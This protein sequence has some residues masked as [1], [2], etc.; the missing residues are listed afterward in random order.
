MRFEPCCPTRLARRSKTSTASRPSAID[1]CR[2]VQTAVAVLLDSLETPSPNPVRLVGTGPLVV[3]PKS[4]TELVANT[5]YVLGP[6][7]VDRIVLQA[8]P[9]VRAA[10]AELLRDRLDVLYEVGLDALDSLETST[11]VEVFTH[12]RHYQYIIVLNT[13]SDVFRSKDVRRAVNMAVDRNAVVRDALN[14]HGVAS[15]GPVWPQN[16][17]FRPDLPKFEFDAQQAAAIL[18]RGRARTKDATVHFTCLVPPDTVNERLALVV[19]K[20]LEAVGV[21]MVVEEAPMDRIYEA[22]KNRRFEAAL[23]D[24]IGG[25]TLLRPYQ[26]WHS[27]HLQPRRPWQCGCRRGVRP[28]PPFGDRRR[29]HAGRRG[30]PADLHGRSAWDLPRL[31]RSGPRGQQTVQRAGV[32]TRA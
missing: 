27:K 32:R 24:G 26:V 23:A 8:F 17:G 25:P 16:Y 7:G 11:R 18:S 31:V 1:R 28:G 2:Q 13:E 22:L 12:T 10:W 20:Q 3:D 21:E 6:P 30:P 14:G 5:H 9:S 19:K 29:I 4:P 15:S